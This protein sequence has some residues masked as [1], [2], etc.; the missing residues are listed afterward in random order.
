MPGAVPHTSTWAL[1]NVTLPYVV[2]LAEKGLHRAVAEDSALAK[3]VN[4]V[5]GKVVLREVAQAH[6]MPHTTLAEALG[7]P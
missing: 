1:A 5:G 4:V 6:A 2:A 3:G 7:R